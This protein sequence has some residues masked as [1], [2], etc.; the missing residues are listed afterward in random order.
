MRVIKYLGG[1]VLLGGLLAIG[2]FFYQG[3]TISDVTDMLSEDAQLSDAQLMKLYQDERNSLIAG[4]KKGSNKIANDYENWQAASTIP[5]SPGVHSNRYMMTY[6]NDIGYET[7][8][9]YSSQ[10]PDMPIGTKIAKESFTVK[11]KGKFSPSP[12]FT[13]EKI[14]A[15]NAPETDGW[16]YARVNRNGRK[17]ITSQKFC[18]AC[19]D[20]FKSQDA[21]G[22]PISKAR[23]GYQARKED[24]S[25]ASLD[26]GNAES[27]K[28][29]FETCSSCHNIG[30]DA[31]NAFGPALTNI[32]GRKAGSFAGYKY[33]ADLKAAKDKG[34]IWTDERLYEWL[35][36]PSE[37]LQD[38]LGDDH[39]A[40]KMPLGF[41]DPQTR[42]D[43]IAYLQSQ[44][45]RTNTQP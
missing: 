36:N 1:L 33:S 14:G 30:P 2:Y 3:G 15:D 10:N 25:L 40:S 43:V 29:I 34:L 45:A 5:A 21:L 11:G 27:G 6:V 13:M 22:Y 41:E 38:Y 32:I 16:F 12:L 39:A 23:L 44:S 9:Q 17:M 8:T 4:Y 37:F 24:V 31:K 35:A 42:N 7:Y 18:H 19:H 20:A 26:A 28:D